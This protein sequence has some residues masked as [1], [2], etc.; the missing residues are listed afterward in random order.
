MARCYH[1]EIDKIIDIVKKNN[2]NM[3][4]DVHKIFEQEIENVINESTP[5]QNGYEKAIE[6]M[7]NFLKKV[8]ESK[9]R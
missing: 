4:D 9:G 7:T 5:Y 2:P 3:I 8:R 6:N 1:K